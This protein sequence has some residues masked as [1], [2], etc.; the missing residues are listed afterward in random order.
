MA[1]PPDVARAPGVT[2]T[3]DPRMIER[4]VRQVTSGGKTQEIVA[5]F[6]G[7]VLTEL[8]VSTAGDVRA[9][10]A[11]AREA[12]RAWAARP[13]RE[14]VVPFLRLH[15]AILDRREEILDV[16][17]WET[18]KARRHAFEEVLDSALSTL[19]YARR[20]PGLLEPRRRAGIFP[21]ATRTVEERRPRGTVVVISP[22]NYPLSLGVADVVPA[23]LAGNAVVHKPDTQTALSTLWVIDL[24][25]SLGMPRE[26]WQVV[27][28]DPAELG[29]PL[30]DG[31]GYVA[32]TGSTRAG[33]VI[34]EQAGR[35]LVGCS[36]ELG[37][38]NPMLVLDDAD[39][40]LAA[41]GA[42]RACFSNAGQLCLSIERL[43]VHDSVH[44]AFLERFVRLTGNMRLGTGLDWG[45][46]MGSLTSRR[47]LE[48]V[49]AHVD[50]AVAKGARVLTGGRARPDIGPLFYEPTVL[51]GVDESMNLCRA[52]TF[53]PVVSVYRFSDD[54]EAV[55]RA[56]D[57]D[58]GLNA[59]IW[60]GDVP[61]GRALAAR[62]KAGTVNINEGYGSAYGSYDAPMGGMKS[63]GLGRRHGAEGLLK[64]TEAQT[65][66]SQATWLGFE[67]VL[68]LPYD[69]YA[70][71]LTNVLKLMKRLHLK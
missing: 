16:V 30:I 29:E 9:A 28:G 70:E 65:V 36:L 1:I 71:T 8:P 63:S 62:I 52:E 49:S 51:T 10:H 11:A 24:L 50:D 12:A 45:V 17:Q 56:N 27:L 6:T 4:V 47:Q 43:Y 48:A 26:I 13:A 58:Y 59:S 18:G 42:L 60:T 21:V 3:L 7:E 19:Y 31:A 53:G 25:V 14:R 23:L 41:Q 37:G 35:R 20:A 33:R 57:T 38:K 67:P 68:G 54:D 5:P 66:S 34:A 46:Q 69:R 64:Y 44:D 2:R 15:D 40:D 39:L 55:E 22:W 61:R 32:F